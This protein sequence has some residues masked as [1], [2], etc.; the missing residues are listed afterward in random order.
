MKLRDIALAAI[1]E[2]K[3]PSQVVVM[4]SDI[5]TSG[6]DSIVPKGAAIVVIAGDLM[7]AGMDSDE[8]GMAYLEKE[9]FPWCRENGDKQIVVTAGNHDKFLFRRWAQGRPIDWPQNVHYLIDDSE[10]I[11]GIKF[12]GTPWCPNDREGRFE[13]SE[14]KLKQLFEKMPD[15]VDILVSHTPPYIPGNGIDANED[16]CHEGS[17]ELTE[18]IL[19]KRPHFVVCGHVHSGSRTPAKLGDTTVINVARVE[20]A[21]SVGEHKP[22]YVR[23]W[24]D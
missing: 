6:M 24:K 15:D 5:H 2:D 12:Y 1:A 20:R 16:G 3:S 22:V 9:F 7:G 19:R 23:V 13:C 8:A 10:T 18:A 4:T 17:K 14:R 11:G 21:R